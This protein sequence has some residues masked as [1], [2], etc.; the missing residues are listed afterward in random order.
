V[1]QPRGSF[2]ELLQRL[3][4]S[5]RLTQQELAQAAGLSTRSV[6]DLEQGVILRARSD[7][8][9]LLADALGLTG[10]DRAEFEAVGRGPLPPDRE[11]IIYHGV[12][13]MVLQAD[14]LAYPSDLL[15]LK[16]AQASY[17]LDEAAVRV[18]GIDVTSLPAVGDSLLVVDPLGM[19]SRNLLFLG[20]EPIDIFG[21][22]SIRDFS[23]R[24]LTDAATISP[25]VREISMTLH[26]VGFGLDEAE[27]FESE[28]AGIVEALEGG[29]Y[30]K[31]LL[32]I[33]NR[34]QSRPSYADEGFLGDTLRLK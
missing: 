22:R 12:R 17:G 4:H 7:T 31:G 27:A 9:R 23:R 6:S 2:A 15:V 32:A 16:Y 10:A 20:V 34:A 3:R 25:P 21:Y 1:E 13:L 30:P 29:E 14:A 11:G 33:N 18:A 28:I 26:G 8:V 24:A 5:A 19:A